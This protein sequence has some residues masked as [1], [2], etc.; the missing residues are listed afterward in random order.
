MKSADSIDGPIRFSFL[1]L[2]AVVLF[3]ALRL[4][5][6]FLAPI[7]CGIAAGVIGFPIHEFL[8]RRLPRWPGCAAGL[9]TLLIVLILL[10]PL[11]FIGWGIVG[12]CQQLAPR[13]EQARQA[14]AAK[15]HEEPT[16]AIP[17]VRHMPATWREGFQ[18]ELHRIPERISAAAGEIMKKVGL[19]GAVAA[20]HGFRIILDIVLFVFLLFF[21]FRDGLCMWRALMRLVPLDSVGKTHLRTELHATIVGTIRG[22]FLTWTIEAITAGAA[23]A[24]VRNPAPLLLGLLTFGVSVIP[25]IGAPLVWGPVAIYYLVAGSVWKGC[26]LIAWGVLI[27]GLADHLLRPYLVGRGTSVPFVWMLFSLLG[28]IEVFGL[29][30]VILGPLILSVLAVFI[31]SYLRLTRS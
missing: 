23:F 21:I 3:E 12:E 31:E 20:K 4:L 24:I 14:I 25:S 30:G 9:S 8:E 5:L 7:F 13:V 16:E 11:S 19:L 15:W 2:F 17:A 22:N 26:F 6:P 10:L 27:V 29:I 1:A 18:R 28:G